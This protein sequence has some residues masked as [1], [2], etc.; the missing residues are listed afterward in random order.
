MYQIKNFL[1][2]DDV[3][4]V[5]EKGN[6]KIIEYMKELKLDYNDI[7]FLVNVNKLGI[8]QLPSN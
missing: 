8:I 5:D 4:V 7:L 3:R 6:I 1:D 2:N